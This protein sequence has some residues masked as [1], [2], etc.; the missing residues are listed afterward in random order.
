MIYRHSTKNRIAFYT[1]FAIILVLTF[2]LIRGYLHIVAFSLLA[3]IVLKPL[4]NVLFRWT[5]RRSGL[6]TLATLVAFF[7]AIILPL[8]FAGRVVG[9]QLELAAA[10]I[11]EPGSVEELSDEA[12]SGLSSVLGPNFTLTQ[13][14][15]DQIRAAVVG[16][17]G[18]IAAAV[19]NLGMS[20]PTMLA[21]LFVF[22]G[23]VG[24]LL[25]N[26][27]QFV[28][29]L[30]RLSPLD[31]VVNDL[32]LR[33]IK[34]TVWAMFLA[35]FVIAVVQ[36]LVTGF[37]I[38]LGDVPY[39][40]LWTLLAVVAA[41]LPLGASLVALPL[42]F[43]QLLLGNYTEALIILAGYLLV[44][45]NIDTFI[46]PKLVHK[47]A[48][49]N[50]A[51]VLIS[52]LGGYQLFGFFGVVYGPV[53]MIL[54]LTTIEVYET[55][56]AGDDLQALPVP[57]EPAAVVALEQPTSEAVP[58]TI[59]GTAPRAEA[60]QAVAGAALREGTTSLTDRPGEPGVAPDRPDEPTIVPGRPEAPPA[61]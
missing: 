55:Y 17:A 53:L 33:R 3:V 58:Q 49:L 59:D 60:P 14:Q 35:I 20:I 40:P 7:L 39:A 57:Q 61:T 50:F 27:E 51:L 9:N 36:G 1:L 56:Y 38:W 12:T 11:Q 45:S 2:W 5:G 30:K 16:V 10:D 6:A 21:S 4:Y 23:I 22:L 37:F 32:F 47:E 52:A 26:Y 54:F 46:R 28:Q 44:V 43:A 34:L 24:V 41:M 48:S 19:V 15:H 25:P 8:W 18:R 13:E 29:R 42:G 31:D